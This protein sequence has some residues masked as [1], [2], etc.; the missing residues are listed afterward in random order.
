MSYGDYDDGDKDN[1]KID[2]VHT[3]DDNNASPD[4]T[5]DGDSNK[6]KNDDHKVIK[7]CSFKPT[8]AVAHDHCEVL[9]EEFNVFTSFIQGARLKSRLRK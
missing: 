7:M 6:F 9:I 2:D 3:N 4:N 1:N 5:V 8:W